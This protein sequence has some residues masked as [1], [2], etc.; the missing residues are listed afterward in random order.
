VETIALRKNVEYL[1]NLNLHIKKGRISLK[2]NGVDSGKIYNSAIVEF[3]EF[4]EQKGMTFEPVNVPFVLSRDEKLKLLISNETGK[5]PASVLEIKQL[6]ILELGEASYTWTR[7]LRFLIGNFQKLFVSGIILPL[8]FFGLAVL[9]RR[10]EFQ[11]AVILLIVPVYYICFQ[12]F[13][14]TEYRYVLALHYFIFS[15]AAVGL[16]ALILKISNFFGHRLK[17]SFSRVSNA[18]S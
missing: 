1:L 12:S 11:P 18:G 5:P 8:A 2:I 15:F 3:D 7:P 9:I 16:S 17:N 14:H 13:L 10:K 6:R 4:D